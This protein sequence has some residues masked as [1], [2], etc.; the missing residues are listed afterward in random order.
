ML[1]IDYLK[2]LL[3]A[4]IPL[5]TTCMVHQLTLKEIAGIGIEEYSVYTNLLTMTEEDIEDLYKKS[6][7]P[8]VG[9]LITNPFEFLLLRASYNRDFFVELQ[10]ALITYIR[11]QIF[12]SV[13]S[14]EIYIGSI[15]QERKITVENFPD[16]QKII[17]AFNR[18]AIIDDEMGIAPGDDSE[19]A[20]L[21]RKR[22]KDRLKAKKRSSG[23]GQEITFHDLVSSVI[24]YSGLTPS[25]IGDYTVYQVMEM[26]DRFQ[27][28]D[29]FHLD[30]QL[31]AAGADSKK[32]HPKAWVVDLKDN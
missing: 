30:V 24:C 3:G 17:M 22:K 8:V 25:Q 1:S 16:L 26:F 21:F 19:I 18:K 32:I 2:I 12:I 27:A 13:D 9:G 15:E 31:L 6:K 28:R 10:K 20:K 4:A 5:D 23:N 11:E 7:E 29:K 14:K